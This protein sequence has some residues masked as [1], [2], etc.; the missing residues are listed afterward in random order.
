MIDTY[1]KAQASPCKPYIVKMQA[2]ALRIGQ[3]FEFLSPPRQHHADA[4][5][6]N[7]ADDAPQ[8][9]AFIHDEPL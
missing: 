9:F 1:S 6:N 7:N 2:K 5:K 3:W 4:S 8:N